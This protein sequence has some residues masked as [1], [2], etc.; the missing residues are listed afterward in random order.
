[1]EAQGDFTVFDISGER[2][3]PEG[4][5]MILCMPADANAVSHVRLQAEP[6]DALRRRI[7]CVASRLASAKL[8]SFAAS[9]A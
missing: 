2:Q 4:T 7:A 8:V 3:A 9:S 1:M 5:V 6:D